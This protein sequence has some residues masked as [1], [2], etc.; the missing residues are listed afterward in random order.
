M[1]ARKTILLVVAAIA[2]IGVALLVRSLFFG[3][4]KAVPAAAPAAV[5]QVLVAA[6]NIEPGERVDAAAV[7]WQAWPRANV[8]PTF[9]SNNGQIPVGGLIDGAVAHTP[10]RKGEPLTFGKIVKQG[11]GGYMAATLSAG[12]RAISIAVSP[13]SSAGGFILPGNRVDIIQTQNLGGKPTAVIILS[14]VRILAVDQNTEQPAG[15]PTN[16]DMH[17]VT[18]EL[19]PEDATLLAQRQVSGAL[20][21]ALRPLSDVAADSSGAVA[22]VKGRFGP[23]EGER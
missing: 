5:V 14:N 15:K 19:S 10:I 3:S 22:I 4:P 9:I 7:T 8:D 1:N 2:A 12:M 23:T 20:S 11:G 16:N 21:L 17:A 18:L 13:V 6:R